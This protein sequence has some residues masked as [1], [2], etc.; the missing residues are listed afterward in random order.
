M[1]FM[2]KAN[3]IRQHIDNVVRIA[4]TMGSYYGEVY[5]NIAAYIETGRKHEIEIIVSDHESDIKTFSESIGSRPEDVAVVF[6]S[7]IEDKQIKPLTMDASDYT[8]EEQIR[9]INF[10]NLVR[11]VGD[12]LP[13]P[14]FVKS[15][16]GENLCPVKNTSN[17]TSTNASPV[18]KSS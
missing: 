8:K 10:Y 6:K 16:K 1:L 18:K 3:T 12:E 17:K 14:T 9:I 7:L 13:A 5:Y 2:L 4:N 15:D 11:E